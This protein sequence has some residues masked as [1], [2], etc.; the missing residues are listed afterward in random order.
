MLEIRTMT[1]D[2]L[3]LGMRLKEQAGWNQTLADW[4]RILAIQPDGCF[5]ADLDGRPVGTTTT[6]VFDTI[7][8]IAMVLVDELAR[9]QGVGRRLMQHALAYLDALPV[10][11]VRL[12]ATPLGRPLY[13]RLGFVA[14]Y[15]LSR[16]E[17]TAG[18]GKQSP[19]GVAAAVETQLPAICTL[20]RHV[21]GTDR[22][23][24]IERLYQQRPDAMQV[25]FADGQLAGYAALRLGTRATQ[26]GP[27]VTLDAAA[28]HVLAEAALNRCAGQPIFL[29]IPLANRP[30]AQWAQTQGLHI[31]R[32][33]TRMRR[34]AA[35]DDRPENLWASF[36]P[37]KG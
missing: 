34:G 19:P 25:A 18:F 6:C 11:T 12:D 21:T 9:G 32:P 16:W 10:R 7:A 23:R 29:D 22:R 4:R 2:D 37:E 26:I 15:E 27:I 14:E 13:E 33:L 30:A 17:G 31:Q 20:D 35:V 24:L 36:G 5:V 8:W 1:A 28:G 3:P